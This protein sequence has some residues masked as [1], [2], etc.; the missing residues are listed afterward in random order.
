MP[1]GLYTLTK[2]RAEFVNG[3]WVPV[4]ELETIQQENDVNYAVLFRVI[5]TTF[6]ST[7]RTDRNNTTGASS[8]NTVNNIAITSRK[9]KGRTAVSFNVNAFSDTTTSDSIDGIFGANISGVP[10]LEFIPAAGG[11]PAYYQWQKRWDPPATTTRNINSLVIAPGGNTNN[12]D[13]FSVVALASPCTQTTSEILTARYQLF[14]DVDEAAQYVGDLGYSADELLN[15]AFSRSFGERGA[16]Y[17]DRLQEETL[18]PDGTGFNDSFF[19]TGSPGA[20][21][22]NTLEG[23]SDFSRSFDL[24]NNVG[25]FFSSLRLGSFVSN[26]PAPLIPYR[27][28]HQIDLRRPTDSVIQNTFLRSQS[29]TQPAWTSPRPFLDAAN[30]GTSLGSAIISD[31]ITTDSSWDYSGWPTL[32]KAEITTGGPVGTAE[33]KISKRQFT[34]FDGSATFNSRDN[35]LTWM[36][37]Q[38]NRK[39]AEVVER[40]HGAISYTGSSNRNS[41]VAGR[42]TVVQRYS[43]PEFVTVDTDGLNI[44]NLNAKK[45]Q[46]TIDTLSSPALPCTSIRQIRTFEDGTILVACAV[47]GLWRIDRTPGTTSWTVT[48]IVPAGVQ[49]TNACYGICTNT[50]Y[51]DLRINNGERWYA[52]F[53]QEF[54]YSDDQGANWTVLNNSTANQFLITG[55]ADTDGVTANGTEE[56]KMNGMVFDYYAFEANPTVERFCILTPINFNTTTGPG[57]ITW[58]SID[59]SAATSSDQQFFDSG[60]LCSNFQLLGL[61]HI[62]PGPESAT[63]A[64]WC[65]NLYNDDTYVTAQWGAATN[66]SFLG[67]QNDRC[68]YCPIY[69]PT[70]GEDYVFRGEAVSISASR[71]YLE[72]LSLVPTA[73]NPGST[74]GAVLVHNGF[75][76]I[77]FTVCEYLGSGVAITPVVDTSS[78]WAWHIFHISDEDTGTDDFRTGSFD[79]YDVYGWDGANWV[80]DNPNSKLTHAGDEPIVDGLQIR[81]E[82][83]PGS[84]GDPGNFVATDFYDT[85]VADG[86]FKDDATRFDYSLRAHIWGSIEGTTF[87]PAT[88]PASPVG[89]VTNEPLLMNSKTGSCRFSEPGWTGC[90]AA[91]RPFDQLGDFSQQVLTGDFS[92]KYNAYAHYQ[93]GGAFTQEGFFGIVR[94]ADKATWYAAAPNNADPLGLPF[95]GMG[96]RLDPTDNTASVAEL[97]VVDNTTVTQITTLTDYDVTDDWEIRRT[98][99]AIEL[100]RNAVAIH[101]F[102]SSSDDMVVAHRWEIN[103][104]MEL[105]NVTLDYTDASIYVEVDGLANDNNFRDLSTYEYDD[106]VRTIELDGTPAVIITDPLAT[107]APGEVVIGRSGRLLFNVADAGKTVTGSY[108]YHLKNKLVSNP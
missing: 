41:I 99:G 91:R 88:V 16:I 52:I 56:A 2:H 17:P 4:E 45:P 32:Y 44:W 38:R 20:V 26:P 106:G 5:S 12:N 64:S 22:S 42:D 85:Y 60:V 83:D 61:R 108:R 74:A 86:V 59:G 66:T 102:S 70:E 6:S 54:C 49:N 50:R 23:Y 40:I 87:V 72:K 29:L 33:Y 63:V 3:E 69:N 101:T 34:Q 104:P 90:T 98:S 97:W 76:S 27:A 13:L 68:C 14:F 100:Y 89:A 43:Y 47:T 67:N 93:S 30:V 95:K 81:F 80:K 82:E 10:G 46:L 21:S 62:Y 24:N 48:Q 77:P 39:V 25:Q 96:L 78:S 51:S 31:T 1:K 37:N 11:N 94:D 107:P 71:T 58:W 92:I 35:F 105:D 53:G 103:H 84:P 7:V 65:F 36:P 28:T 15:I 73:G 79:V 18:S 19:T 8:I 57:Q 9:Y 55:Y 75:E